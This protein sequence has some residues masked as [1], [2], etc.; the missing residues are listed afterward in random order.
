MSSLRRDIVTPGRPEVCEVSAGVYAYIQPD[1]T[2]W[3]NNTGF[4]T[5]PQ[6]VISIDSCATQRR[7]QAYLD[8]ITAVTP[9]PV[10][11]VVNTH[12][13][14]DHTFGNCMFPAATLIAH[15]RARAEAIAFGPPRELPRT[16]ASLTVS[17]RELTDKRDRLERDVDKLRRRIAEATDELDLLQRNRLELTWRPAQLEKQRLEQYRDKLR[18]HL[19][20]VSSELDATKASI[21]ETRDIL[22]RQ[23]AVAQASPRQVEAMTVPCP[24]CGQPSVP[25]RAGVG[26]RGWRKGWYECSADDCDAA[27]S[28]RWSR[29]IYPVIKMA[30]L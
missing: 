25:Q 7:T 9:A 6:G 19:G 15:E 4:L 8:A 12:H 28:A 16:I 13:H 17:F 14:G 18:T 26:G 1:G 29:G 3:I 23:Y 11:A 10:R 22:V 2:W 24:V 20:A 5:G 27:W 30:G 21:G